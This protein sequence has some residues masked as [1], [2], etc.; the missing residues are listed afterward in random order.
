M[1]AL[2]ISWFLAAAPA[3]VR[4][5]SLKFPLGLATGPDRALYVSEREGHRVVRIDPT[6]GGMRVVAGTGIPGFSG[7]GGPATSAQLRCPDSID[8]D[9]AG[10]LYI[11]DR[12]NERL[13]VVE[14]G[15]GIIRT[16]AGNGARGQSPDGPALSLSL[17]GPFFLESASRDTLLFTDTDANLVRQVDLRSG[18]VSTLAGTGERGFSG[19]GGPA[20]SARLTRPHIA[21]RAR[22]GDLI[23]GDSFNQRIRRVD[24]TTGV[25]RTI[26]GNGTEGFVADGTPAPEAPF[27]YFGAMIELEN[28]DLVFDEWAGH[29][30]LRL[31]QREQRIRVLAGTQDSTATDAEGSDPVKTR[32]GL[33][34]GMVRDSQG[35]YYVVEPEPGRVT[36]IDLEKRRVE[37]VVGPKRGS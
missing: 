36:R 18:R 32:F 20:Y 27:K 10:N 9:D 35:R 21:F 19:D 22:N 33:L 34:G 37:T 26:A 24:H 7:D 2:M 30:L 17:M 28:G 8:F 4:A 1:I 3:V 5:D 11:A 12:C 16:I 31:D 6:S 13:R 29:M 23:I 14:A 25:I 15:T